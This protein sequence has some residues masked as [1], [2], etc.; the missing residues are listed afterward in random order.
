[1]LAARRC[2]DLTHE[3]SS[4][5]PLAPGNSPALSTWRIAG[6]ATRP[7]PQITSGATKGLGWETKLNSAVSWSAQ[8]L[9]RDHLVTV[10]I[11]AQGRVLAVGEKTVQIHCIPGGAC[12]VE[13][14]T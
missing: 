4:Q 2:A 11:L 5:G 8:Q 10:G 1:M 14:F 3:R 13:L 9:V 7:E 12:P 6:Q